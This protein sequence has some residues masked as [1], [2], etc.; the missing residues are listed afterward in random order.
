MIWVIINLHLYCPLLLF[1]YQNYIYLIGPDNL[2]FPM[3]LHQPLQLKF[4]VSYFVA[5]QHTYGTFWFSFEF[6]VF[7]FSFYHW[8]FLADGKLWRFTFYS[9]PSILDKDSYYRWLVD[10][11]MNEENFPSINFTRVMGLETCCQLE[12]VP[13]V[14]NMAY[15][16]F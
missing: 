16:S 5:H 10:I 8:I 13:F 3:K 2:F 1:Y 12:S 6:V 11:W 7:C 9:E 4:I 15:I 14:E